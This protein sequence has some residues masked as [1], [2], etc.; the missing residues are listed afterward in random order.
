M[1]PDLEELLALRKREIVNEINDLSKP[2]GRSRMRELLAELDRLALMARVAAN[3]P[4]ARRY[5]DIPSPIAA[6]VKFLEDQ[7]IPQTEDEVIN[8]VLAGGWRGG[9]RQYMGA[10][11]KSIS[12]FTSPVGK[13]TLSKNPLLRV[14]GNRIGLKSWG[15]ER[16]L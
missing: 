11:H 13:G 14:I 9:K 6:V 1:S 16:W 12:V 3:T 10:L 7:D 15:E 8:G 5:V 2:E 4:D